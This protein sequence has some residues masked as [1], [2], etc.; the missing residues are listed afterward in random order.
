MASKQISVSRNWLF[1]YLIANSALFTAMIFI[2][3]LAR[4]EVAST[5][6]QVVA[7]FGAGIAGI[8]GAAI[9]LRTQPPINS[10]SHP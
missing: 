7:L 5:L 6:I 3:G 2:I 9:P 1:T 8:A 10:D 4:P